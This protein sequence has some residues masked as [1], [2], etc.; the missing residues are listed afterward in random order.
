MAELITGLSPQ[1][2]FPRADLSD[3]N[4]ELLELMMANA[5]IVSRSHQAAE[6]ASWLFRVGHATIL[7]G[8]AKLHDGD[9]RLAAVH[10]GVSTYEAITAFICGASMVSDITVI[11]NNSAKLRRAGSHEISNYVETSLESFSRD[12][13][14]TSEVITASTRR[15]HG[16]LTSYAILG[17]AMS[18][19]FEL[20]SAA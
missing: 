5:D 7:H 19:Q 9:E 15:F 18:R 1:P 17:A 4:A 6:Q 13:P 14:R 11:N 8:A 2:D 3:S 12:M 10:S 20:D 16:P